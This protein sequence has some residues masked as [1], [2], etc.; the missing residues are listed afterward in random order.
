MGVKLA[1]SDLG[2]VL[3]AKAFGC[4]LTLLGYVVICESLA[5]KIELST[6]ICTEFG[7]NLEC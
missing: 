4:L 6:K 2:I 7:N 5:S 3:R 1:N